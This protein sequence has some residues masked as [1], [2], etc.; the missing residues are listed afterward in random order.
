MIVDTFILTDGGGRGN[1]EDNCSF[2]KD[3]GKQVFVLAD[4]LGGHNCGEVAS[5]IAVNTFIRLCRDETQLTDLG[6]IIQKTDDVLREHQVAHPENAGMRTTIVAAALTDNSLN[7]C[8]IGDSRFY[9]FRNG[10]YERRTRDHSL[11]QHRFD[12]G[13]LD[14]IQ[15]RFSE[16]QNKLSKVLGNSNGEL[17]LPAPYETLTVTEGDAF[18]LCSDGFW[19]Y[20]YETEMELDLCKSADAGEWARFMLKRLLLRVSGYND[21]YSLICGIIRAG[22]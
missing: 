11:P 12:A 21:N 6:A 14:E 19:E 15:L 5:E 3:A 2:F 7:Y 1:N 10:T 13:E 20:V 4:G 22:R 18:L 17:K 16:D 9:F 8:N